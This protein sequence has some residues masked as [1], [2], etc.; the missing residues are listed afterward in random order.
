MNVILTPTDKVHADLRPLDFGLPPGLEA[1]EPPE[2]RGLRRDGVRLLI[3][4]AATD[5]ITHTRFTDIGAFLYPG[6]VLVINTSGT[7]PS[8]LPALRADGTPLVLHLSTHQGEERWVVEIRRPDLTTGATLPF[9]DGVSGETLV[10]PDGGRVT[11]IAPHGRK[12]TSQGVRLWNAD[13]RL[14]ESLEEYLSWYARP[15]RYG[16]VRQD[17]PIEMYQTVYATETGSA[18]MPSAGR[19]FTPELITSL[20]ARGIEFAPL[21]LH[22]GV[23]SLEDHEPPYAEF[24]RVSDETARVVNAA[25]A[26]GKRVIAVGTTVVRALETV[27][28]DSGIIHSDEGWTEEIITPERGVRAA[29]GLLTG[30]HEPKATHLSML[31][32]FAGRAHLRRV[33]DA[34]LREG[35]LW[36]EF[37]DLH[38]LI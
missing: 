34:A 5:R 29:N 25:K 36:H 23:A 4:E 9:R 19:A 26:A 12:A 31:E 15:I 6:D 18:E 27:T 8:A 14:P 2:A 32:A 13:L 22:T 33:Y 35:Y 10:L 21:T 17:W 11:L 1:A 3:S 24:Y 37:G 16:Y 38:L 7:R 20:A 28:D 30:F